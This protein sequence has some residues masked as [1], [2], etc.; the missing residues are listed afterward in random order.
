MPTIKN[1]S[2][3][4]LSIV[5]ASGETVALGPHE[6]VELSEDDLKSEAVQKQIKQGALGVEKQ[7][8][9]VSIPEK[10]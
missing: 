7:R 4:P 1:M 8:P 3:G 9:D 2:Y 5:R 6:T 10:K